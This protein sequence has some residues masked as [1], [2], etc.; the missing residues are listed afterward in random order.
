[1]KRR[2]FGYTIPAVIAMWVYSFYTMVNGFFVSMAVGP[3]ALAAVN[4]S[5]PFINLLYGVSVLCS[6]GA[7]SVIS[8]YLGKGDLKQASAAFMTNFVVLAVAS[9]VLA[10]VCLVFTG[11]IS[12]FLGSTPLLFPYVTSYIGTIF[13]FVPFFVLSYYLEI[14]TRTDGFPRLSTLAVAV[15][16]V[17]NI[18]LDYLFVIVF[19]WGARGAACATGFAQFLSTSLLIAHFLADRGRL[20]ICCFRCSLAYVRRGMKLGLGDSITEF[21]VGAVIFLFNRRILAIVGEPGVAGYTVIAYVTTFVLMTAIGIA[22]GAQPLVAYYH[23]RG[24]AAGCARLLRLALSGAAVCSVAWFIVA[25]AFTGAIVSLFIDPA[26][27][28]VLYERTVSAFKVYAFSYLFVGVNVVLA[29]FFSSIERPFF[30]VVVSV[31]R[32]FVVVTIFLFAMSALLGEIGIWLTPT[33][34]EA[35]C[36]ALAFFLFYRLRRERREE[37]CAGEL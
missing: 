1:M 13:P 11:E 21:S 36:T 5:M 34:S 9:V 6:M 20:A 3:M 26:R 4:I 15:A 7:S 24:N 8:I 22:Q 25:E 33:A 29:T 37:V 12:M 27:E 32:G 10:V 35:F 19:G 18:A 30:G 2:F 23:G 14:C 16:A 31:A 28:Y 17:T